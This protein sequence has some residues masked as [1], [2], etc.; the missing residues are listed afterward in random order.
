M[1]PQQQ[2]NFEYRKMWDA[3]AI[4]NG[5]TTPFETWS[6]RLQADWVALVSI[7]NDRWTKKMG[8]SGRKPE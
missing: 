3:F 8:S 5:I 6:A 7:L 4:E 2:Y 1:T